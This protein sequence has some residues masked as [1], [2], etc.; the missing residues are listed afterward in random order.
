MRTF[1]FVLKLETSE[2]ITV[3]YD[4]HNTEYSLKI[5]KQQNV[6]SSPVLKLTVFVFTDLPVITGSLETQFCL[7]QTPTEMLHSYACKGL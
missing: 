3:V 2:R 7:A 1:R 6:D 5:S 4:L